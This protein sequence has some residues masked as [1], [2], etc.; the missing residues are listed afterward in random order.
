M[1]ENQMSEPSK[2][3]QDRVDGDVGT[4]DLATSSTSN[5]LSRRSFLGRAGTST[6]VAAASIG[7]PSLLLTENVAARG[8]ARMND[9]DDD[10]DD[11][12]RRARSFRI[13]LKAALE[14][15][16]TPTPQQVSNHDE[17]RYPNFIGNYSQGLPHNAIGE[18]DLPAYRALLTAVKSGDPEDFALIPLG[19]NTKLRGPARR[20]SI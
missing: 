20:N 10:E 16:D 12:S 11:S 18:V 3:N 15:R 8:P 2:R 19:G 4:K 17:T 5:S 1:S 13:R 6:A 9:H 14:Q 7:L